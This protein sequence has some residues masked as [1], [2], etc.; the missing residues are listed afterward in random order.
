MYSR[1]GPNPYRGGGQV[2]NYH[3][4]NAYANQV[5]MGAPTAQCYQVNFNSVAVGK[6]V[7]MSKRR[8]RWRF[9]FPNQESLDAGKSG[10]DCRGE[11]HDVNLVWSVTSGKKMLMS[12][13]QQLYSGTNKARIFEYSWNNKN[14]SQLRIVVH[15]T[16]PMSN[17]QGVRQYD[18]FINGKSFFTMPKVYEIGLKGSASAADARIPGVISDSQRGLLEQS[19]PSRT[20]MD[21]SGSG[22]AMVA[23]ASAQEEEHD[24]KKAIEESLRESR[25][26]LAARGRLDDQSI[27]ASTLTYTIAEHPASQAEQPLIDLL[28]ESTPV[29]A[30]NTQALVPVAGGHA[31]YQL[32]D[33]FAFQPQPQPHFNAAPPVP[34]FPAQMDEFAPQAPSYNDISNQILMG[35][36]PTGV[37]N[38]G[39]AIPPEFLPTKTSVAFSN[40]FDD[41]PATTS[42]SANPFDAPAT[43]SAYGA[44]VGYDAFQQPQMQQAPYQQQNNPNTVYGANSAYPQQQQ[45]QQQQ[46]HYQQQSYGNYHM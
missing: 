15:S 35:Y 31:Q 16:L 23:P 26:H 17:T 1:S 7:A 44:P 8:I 36:S 14:G 43:T 27:A 30:S 32:N 10:I 37:P 45:Q 21:Y 33:P 28:G 12:N 3:S 11:E 22:R 34:P 13:G 25:A 29:P 5:P 18:L 40:P 19:S 2:V 20:P 38:P 4:N 24:L 42:A 46:T 6:V 9:G 41:A 39:A